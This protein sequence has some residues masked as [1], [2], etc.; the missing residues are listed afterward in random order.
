M[1]HESSSSH[2]TPTFT[3]LS[4]CKDPRSQLK[5]DN[6]LAQNYHCNPLLPH[7]HSLHW[8]PHRSYYKN[9]SKI[10]EVSYYFSL[11]NNHRA[12]QT[13]LSA[14]I[15]S[16]ILHSMLLHRPNCGYGSIH[17]ASENDHVP[18]KLA[19]GSCAGCEWCAVRWLEAGGEG[20][21]IS[22]Y[23]LTLSEDWGHSPPPLHRLP[24]IYLRLACLGRANTLKHYL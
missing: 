1:T 15:L 18:E 19:R 3:L 10:I 11:S 8:Y 22:P 9:D 7:P 4:V 14:K 6:L 16:D 13:Y 5:T 23:L 2:Y 12:L 17:L 20:R 21:W 24:L